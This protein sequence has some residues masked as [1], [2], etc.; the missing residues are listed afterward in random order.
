MVGKPKF[1]VSCGSQYNIEWFYLFSCRERVTVPSSKPYIS[2]IGT[3]NQASNT[4]ITWNNKASD[5]NSNGVELGTFGSATIT[6][7]SDYF[8]ASQIT[9]EVS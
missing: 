2:F 5:K 8:C 6:I 7:Y 4:V 1:S 9:F 3:E